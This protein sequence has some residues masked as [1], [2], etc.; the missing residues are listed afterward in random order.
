MSTTEA[1]PYPDPGEDVVWDDTLKETLLT[2]GWQGAGFKFHETYV[3]LYTDRACL[4]INLRKKDLYIDNVHGVQLLK[5]NLIIIFTFVI[6]LY[7]YVYF[8]SLRYNF[9][10]VRNVTRYLYIVCTLSVDL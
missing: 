2:P 3:S 5:F 7:P 9:T 6:F 1:P 4:I 10:C 8:Y